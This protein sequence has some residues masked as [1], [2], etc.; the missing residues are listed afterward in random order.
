MSS[1][2]VV[3]GNARL[4]SSLSGKEFRLLVHYPA[5]LRCSSS[6]RFMLILSP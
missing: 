5:S 2:H 6:Y 1:F 4:L 3:V